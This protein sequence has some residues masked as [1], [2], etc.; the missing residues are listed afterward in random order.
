MVCLQRFYFCR[1]LLNFID[2]DLEIAYSGEQCAAIRLL[3]SNLADKKNRFGE[4][5][6]AS[7]EESGRRS[8]SSRTDPLCCARPDGLAPNRLMSRKKSYAAVERRK[9][10]NKKKSDEGDDERTKKTWRH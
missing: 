2:H 7:Q 1:D 9:S 10:N 6:S 3:R 5:S 4:E 8:L